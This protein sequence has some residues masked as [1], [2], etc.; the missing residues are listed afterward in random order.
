[1][2]FLD[3]IKTKIEIPLIQR[4]YV[5]G[6]DEKKANAFLEAIKNGMDRNG[7]NLDFVYGN[8][9]N[10]I[11]IP[12]DGQQRLTTLFLLYYY[13]SI[14]ND[15]ID[16]LKNFSYAIR[17]T[18]KDF[19]EKLTNEDNWKK[20]IKDNIKQQIKNS[21]WYFLSWEDDLTIKSILSMLHLIEQKFKN[22]TIDK[23]DKIEFEFLDL[24]EYSLGEDLYIKMNARGK[25][26]SNFENF[27]AEFEHFIKDPKIKA[28]LDNEWLDI[29]WKLDYVAVD[30]YFYNFFYNTTL[31][32]YL[33]T[34]IL[35]KN[36]LKTKELLDFYKEV[37][38][39]KS[40]YIDSIIVLLDNI[41][42][43]P[44]LKNLCKIKSEAQYYDRLELYIW[45]LSILKQFNNIELKKWERICNNLVNNTRIEDPETFS[46]IL[47]ELL[48]LSC[49]IKDTIYNEINFN[50]I[51]KF[52]SE[53]IKEEKLKI[54]LILD[55]NMW[56]DELIKAENHWYLC[57]Q[58][59]F[60]LEYAKNDFDEFIKYRD[61]FFC[62]F[63]N[64][65]EKDKYLQTLIQRALLTI[66]DYLP[67]H[68]NSDK[69]T[70]CS[71]DTRLRIKNENWREVFDTSEFKTLLDKVTDFN[72]LE[73]LIN[74]Y[75]ADYNDWKSY[76]INPKKKWSVLE[77]IKNYQIIWKN[78]FN[79]F[80]NAGDT[81]A[82]KWGWKRKKELYSFYFY[83]CYKEELELEY[84]SSSFEPSCTYLF[85]DDKYKLDIFY[86]KQKFLV[87]FFEYNN[88]ELSQVLIKYL[89]DNGF[90]EN[91]YVNIREYG[92]W[93][94]LFNLS[95]LDRLVNFIKDFCGVIK[96]ID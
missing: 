20:L 39:E 57:G 79:I 24:D 73:I 38:Y 32:F 96:T 69:Y 91:R 17:P 18:S 41:D 47:Q 88:T 28:K 52:S 36:F 51:G 22:Q 59:G 23:L 92:Y 66:E 14:E 31:N 94:D 76:F 11:F 4:D 8:K 67:Q 12:I 33:E 26:L 70:F 60:L 9:Q 83:K 13:L 34:H 58:I 25:Q 10:D 84:Y 77:N 45:S 30:K 61:K 90:E 37:Y 2:K 74:E 81:S 56:E 48:K 78:E 85:I 62:L 55:N 40:P 7:L 3:I 87:R 93:N 89:E 5:Q 29:F 43:F 54:K 50:N 35:N 6:L 19:I 49:T 64:K 95:S 82:E 68:T 72:D 42:K 75:Y 86:Y 46:N 21:N 1:M 71:F 27:K 65:V 53:Q 15:Y 44:K 63:T 16:E 80:L